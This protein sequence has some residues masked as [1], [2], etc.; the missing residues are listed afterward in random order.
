MRRRTNKVHTFSVFSCENSVSDPFMQGGVFEE[1]R[2]CAF[3]VYSAS[4]RENLNPN[5][6]TRR[7]GDAEKDEDTA[8]QFSRTQ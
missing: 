4:P 5:R 2:N 1:E 3:S 7:R 8:F 6:L